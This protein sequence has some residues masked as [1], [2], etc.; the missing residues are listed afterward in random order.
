MR[1]L[2]RH[3][4]AAESSDVS[5][6]ARTEGGQT[7]LCGTGGCV[8]LH[9]QAAAA[10]VRSAAG[11]GG[12]CVVIGSPISTSARTVADI[13][14]DSVSGAGDLG[15]LTQLDGAFVCFHADNGRRLSVVTDF[16][17]LQPL[18]TARGPDATV[19]AST[20]RTAA[21]AAGLDMDEDAAGI[22]ALLTFGHMLGDRTVI[23]GVERVP[24]AAVIHHRG[25]ARGQRSWWRLP[26][27][28]DETVPA[29]THLA[30][31]QQ[32]LTE[33]FDASMRE[34]PTGT[35]FV[36]GGYDSRLA[37][38]LLLA[39]GRQ[40]HAVCIRRRDQYAELRVAQAVCRVLGVQPDVIDP[41]DD[42]FDSDEYQE[43]VRLTEAATAS[44]FLFIA[45]IELARPCV[46]GAAWDG[47][48]PGFMNAQPYE[49][50]GFGRY[51][52][53]I[54]RKRAK[55]A[56]ELYRPEWLAATL[57][58]TDEL[59]QAEREAWPDT[60]QGVLGFGLRNRARLRF[61][62]NPLQVL[63]SSTP[64]H[65]PGA[66]RAFWEAVGRIP[67]AQRKGGALHMALLSR[68]AP[69]LAR[70]PVQ[71]GSAILG[72]HVG[73]R[74]A[75]QRLRVGTWVDF[76]VRQGRLRQVGAVLN[77][78][79]VRWNSSARSMPLLRAALDEPAVY[80]VDALAPHLQQRS[81]LEPGARH[82]MSVLHRVR[83]LQLQREKPGP[84]SL[85]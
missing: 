60:P 49:C 44:S 79:E 66:T 45:T 12:W 50:A 35:I 22:G 16:L 34:S 78:S 47:L 29:V 15:A 13:V 52:E 27:D 77:A 80:D 56:R 17:G 62:P 70:L 83:T 20:L 4:D 7:V 46:R 31:V 24:A 67:T 85:P 55:I 43:Y 57:T 18:Y 58:A 68:V 72:Y 69:P 23:R 28:V 84:G 71:S 53:K 63:G 51:L 21:A 10:L 30:A 19:Y 75:V 25:E 37:A 8:E 54:S 6:T 26:T 1:Y 2:L 14:A 5:L 33:W 11:V 81:R 82:L 41:P 65:L 42:Y 74:L 36:S 3:C 76:A 9:V 32:A 64:V 39:G 40:P 48:L 73:S 38:G 61:A 59:I